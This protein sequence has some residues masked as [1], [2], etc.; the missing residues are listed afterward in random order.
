MFFFILQ[1]YKKTNKIIFKK[2]LNVGGISNVKFLFMMRIIAT[3][4]EVRGKKNV[5][6]LNNHAMPSG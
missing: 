5:S 3:D 1:E 6:F 4:D 2:Y